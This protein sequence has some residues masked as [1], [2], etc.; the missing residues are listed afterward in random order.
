MRRTRT[1]LRAPTAR[2]VSTRRFSRRPRRTSSWR[3]TLCRR[4]AAIAGESRQRS[5]NF[6]STSGRARATTTSCRKPRSRT[7]G[8]TTATGSAPSERAGRKTGRRGPR[9]PAAGSRNASGESRRSTRRA[10]T[11]SGPMCSRCVST[12]SL[13]CP[14]AD[15]SSAPTAWRLILRSSRRSTGRSR[16]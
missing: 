5:R 2:R 14:R 12:T 4:T 13:E 6:I 11:L 10:S 7:S 9:F 15:S 3:R 8:S 1:S 16:P